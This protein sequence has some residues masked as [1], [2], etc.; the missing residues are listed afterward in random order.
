V[1]QARENAAVIDLR[2]GD[3]EFARLDQLSAAVARLE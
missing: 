1:D 2:L 3:D